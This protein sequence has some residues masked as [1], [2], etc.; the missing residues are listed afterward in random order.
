MFDQQYC[1]VTVYRICE[2]TVYYLVIPSVCWWKRI[3]SQEAVE[4]KSRK[5]VLVWENLKWTKQ[6]GKKISSSLTHNWPIDK[7]SIRNPIR[8]RKTWPLIIV[9]LRR[10]LVEEVLWME[11]IR[12]PSWYLYSQGFTVVVLT[13]AHLNNLIITVFYIHSLLLW[14]HSHEELKNAHETPNLWPCTWPSELVLTNLDLK[15]S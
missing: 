4:N 13:W 10:Y 6:V 9:L 5:K 12:A 1:E 14:L 7:I 2:L 8:A 15:M 11:G 3:H